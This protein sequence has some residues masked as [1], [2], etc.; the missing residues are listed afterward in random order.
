MTI[1]CGATIKHRG[2]IEPCH[3]RT[4]LNGKSYGLSYAGYDIRCEQEVILSPQKPFSIAS[5]IEKFT[6]PNNVVGLVK[7]KSTW[8]RKGLSVFNTVIEPGWRGFLT[9]ELVNHSNQMLH[10]EAG[11]PIAQVIFM[12]TDQICEPYNGKYQDQEAKPVGAILSG[13]I[14][15]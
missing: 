12:Y 13:I 14:K 4:Q 8:A 1:L 7:D 5:S 9:L 3:P 15:P 6:M 11:D 2:I 10:I